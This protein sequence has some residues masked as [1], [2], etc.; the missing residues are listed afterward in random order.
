ME[1]FIKCVLIVIGFLL[2]GGCVSGFAY[3]VKNHNETVELVLFGLYLLFVFVGLP[4]MLTSAS[5]NKET[6][7]SEEIVRERYVDS[8][9]GEP[10]SWLDYSSYPNPKYVGRKYRNRD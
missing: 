6:K 1:R 9:G 4:L 10:R 5:S 2:L 3:A 8:Y 7:S